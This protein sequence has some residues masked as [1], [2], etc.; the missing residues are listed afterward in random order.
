[1]MNPN[2]LVIGA[3]K[4]GTTWLF[5]RLREHPEVFLPERKELNFLHYEQVSHRWSEYWDY[6]AKAD[7]RT[8]A[9]GEISPRYLSSPRAHERAAKIM[10]EGRIIAILRDP[11]SQLASNYWHTRRQNFHQPVPIK[12]APDPIEALDEYP[13]QLWEPIRYGTHLVKWLQHFNRSHI[14]LIE[15]ERLHEAPQLAFNE[16][17]SFLEIDR[18]TIP[19]EQRG[20]TVSDRSGVSPKSAHSERLY[21]ALYRWAARGPYRKLKDVLGI[22]RAERIAQRMNFRAVAQRLFFNPGY[23]A[24]NKAQILALRDRMHSEI[25]LLRNQLSFQPSNWSDIWCD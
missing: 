18:L 4:S 9:V 7:S 3:L 1:M 14:L 11:V 2:F 15:Y 6:F 23:P 22:R 10:P 19:P 25:G 24:L 21:L 17:C 8:K 16:V 20:A 12:H 13:E 5:N